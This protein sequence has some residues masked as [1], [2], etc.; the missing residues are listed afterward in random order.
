MVNAVYDHR[1]PAPS[2]A[3][4]DVQNDRATLEVVAMGRKMGLSL[5]SMTDVINKGSGRNRTSKVMLQTIIDGKSSSSSF[6]MSLMLKDMN[7]AISLGMDAPFV[8]E[9]PLMRI[10][11]A[12][13]W[14]MA[15]SL[16]G[17]PLVDL[18]VEH[19]HTCYT[20]DRTTRHA[21]GYGCGHCPACG[22]RARGWEQWATKR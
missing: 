7:Q 11:K 12:D 18:I 15:Q 20:P 16:G 6:V 14:A 9:T 8:I 19:T 1:T 4:F 5:E 10:D 22:L 17:A 2:G 21:W 13:T 3:P